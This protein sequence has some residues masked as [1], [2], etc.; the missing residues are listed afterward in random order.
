MLLARGAPAGIDGL[1]GAWSRAPY[2][3]YNAPLTEMESLGAI[4][5]SQDRSRQTPLRQ[6]IE[7]DIGEKSLAS[8]DGRRRRAQPLS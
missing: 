4:Q 6:R 5:K 3:T 7:C 8:V 2:W 1:T